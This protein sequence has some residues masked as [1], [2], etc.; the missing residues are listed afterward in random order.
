MPRPTV[1]FSS[2]AVTGAMLVAACGDSSSSSSEEA[3]P[4]SAATARREV[5][6]TREGVQAALAT[7]KQGDHAAADDQVSEAYLQHFEEVEGPLESR[8]HE[9]NE[10]LEHAIRDDL[11]KQMKS[12]A[13]A[14]EVERSVQDILADLDKAEALL[15]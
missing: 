3:P 12:G 1:L 7:Y 4:A 5:G 8:D 15:R 10:D 9:L 11:R 13:P 6:E 14:A 2:L